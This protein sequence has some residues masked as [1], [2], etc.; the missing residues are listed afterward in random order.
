MAA[1]K[2]GKD[3]RDAVKRS[4][5]ER[6][7]AAAAK[8]AAK[9]HEASVRLGAGAK[10]YVQRKREKKE[11][12]EMAKASVRIQANFRGRKER[13]D[14]TS[15]VNV[16]KA[17]NASDPQYQAEKYMEQHKLLELFDL[18]GQQLVQH[19]PDNPRAFLIDELEKLQKKKEPHSPLHFFTNEDVETLY[20]M[21]D[22]SGLGLTPAQC[23]E[24]LVALGLEKVKVPPAVER[25]DRNAF[26][27]L[28]PMPALI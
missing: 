19:K 18:L 10:G 24:A 22:A 23:Q 16:R 12:E 28:L 17:R 27:N 9:E 1:A 14:P 7:A 3:A 8:E 25:F 6:A 15:E 2:R 13:D 5:E 11:R 4:R 26:M 21:Y 20:S